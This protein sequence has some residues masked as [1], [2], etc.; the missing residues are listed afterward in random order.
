MLLA[1]GTNAIR[2]RDEER[3]ARDVGPLAPV[4]Q[5]DSTSEYAGF[6]LVGP[7]VDDLL[8]GLTPLDITAAGLPMN[9]CAETGLAGVHALLVRAPELAVPS[10]RI[11]VGWD[12]GEYVWQELLEVGGQYG[13][14]PLGIDAWKSL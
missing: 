2:V 1:S 7:R 12:L 14:H 6:S 5:R 8:R 13:I 11:Y 4:S 9:S 10:V 3:G